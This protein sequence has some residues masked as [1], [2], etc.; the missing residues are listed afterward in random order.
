MA[1]QENK[2]KAS[3]ECYE[4]ETIWSPPPLYLL[5]CLCLFN[6]HVEHGL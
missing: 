6:Q 5:E 2:S 4:K 3:W 1:I